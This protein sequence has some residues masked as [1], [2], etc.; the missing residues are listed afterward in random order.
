MAGKL[1]DRVA[2]LEGKTGDLARLERFMDRLEQRLDAIYSAQTLLVQRQ[3]QADE[4][5]LDL[6]RKMDQVIAILTRHS[7]LIENL[8]AVIKEKIGFT[9]Q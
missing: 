4:R 5:W 6:A 9:A 3:S 1:E 8:P 7:Q 2:L